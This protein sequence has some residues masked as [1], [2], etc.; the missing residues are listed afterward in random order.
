MKRIWV[1]V[2]ISMFVVSCGTNRLATD[3]SYAQHKTY[4]EDYSEKMRLVESHFPEIYGLFCNGEVSIDSVYTY[5]EDGEK[6]VHVDY[7][8]LKSSDQV[9]WW[10]LLLV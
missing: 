2:A 9:P 1:M 4:V 8:Y 5:E 3:S 6:K 10:L 7:H